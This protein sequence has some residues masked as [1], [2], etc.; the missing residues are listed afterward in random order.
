METPRQVTAR[1]LFAKTKAPCTDAKLGKKM[2]DYLANALPDEQ[3]KKMQH[4]I[5]CCTSC[6]V[7]EANMI[8]LKATL[9]AM[10]HAAKPPA[11]KRTLH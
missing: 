7:F 2:A 10:P 5:G 6:A 9:R 3:M 11:K 4:H 8:N 1:I